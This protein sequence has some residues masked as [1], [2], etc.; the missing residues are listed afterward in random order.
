MVIRLLSCPQVETRLRSTKLEERLPSEAQA[1]ELNSQESQDRRCLGV[2]IQAPILI[3]PEETQVLLM[4]GANQ[5]IS[6]WTPG[7]LTLCLLKVL[8]HVSPIHYC[9]E[10]V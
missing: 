8:A 2:L 10:T 1:P 7:Q 5:L 9:N 3:I 6:F 4:V